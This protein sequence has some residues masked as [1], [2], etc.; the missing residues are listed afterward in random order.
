MFLYFS[1]FFAD[2]SRISHRVK[3]QRTNTTSISVLSQITDHYVIQ[4]CGSFAGIA[5]QPL[6][7]II[8]QVFYRSSVSLKPV[9]QF[10][11]RN[12]KQQL[13]VLK[14]FKAKITVTKKATIAWPVKRLMNVANEPVM[15]YLQYLRLRFIQLSA[16]GGVGEGGARR[17]YSQKNWLRLCRPLPKTP[18]PSWPKYALFPTLFVTWP[19]IWYPI[20]DRCG[21]PPRGRGLL[22]YMGYVGMC[23][24]KGY[25][26]FSRLGHK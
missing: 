19:K 16:P 22:P 2:W 24:P 4:F 21:L 13:N 1:Q 6:L 25:G 26:F 11:D 20:Y 14:R 10:E 3:H 23:G 7:I 15:I 8:Y 17:G 9:R 18:I 5:T 12:S